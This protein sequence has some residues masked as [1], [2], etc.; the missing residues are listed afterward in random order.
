MPIKSKEFIQTLHKTQNRYT[1]KTYIYIYV[2]LS[3]F[4]LYS[5]SIIHGNPSRKIICMEKLK[6]SSIAVYIFAYTLKYARTLKYTV[7]FD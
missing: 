3:T 2:T 6:Y 1:N 5:L 7:D 4:L